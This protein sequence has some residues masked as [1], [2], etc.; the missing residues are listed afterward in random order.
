MSTPP[1]LVTIGLPV[2]NGERYLDG[3]LTSVLSQTYKDLELIISDN[4]STDATLDICRRFCRMDSRVRYMRSPSN[5]GAAWNYN[6]VFAHARGRYFRWLG[7]DDRCSDTYLAKL[8]EVLESEARTTVAVYP[9]TQW[10]DAEGRETT[11]ADPRYDL[12]SPVVTRRL[13]E[14]LRHVVYCNPV[15]GLIRAD[16]LRKTGL[17]RPFISSDKVLL[18]E[19]LLQ[20]KLLEYGEPLFYRRKHALSSC[21]ANRSYRAKAVWFDPRN[22]QRV[23][24]L[25]PVNVLLC[26]YIGAVMKS[27]LGPLQKTT[28]LL[29]VLR[30]HLR[31][32]TV[33]N[34]GGEWKLALRSRL[35]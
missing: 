6:H 29:V 4:G 3:A 5:R 22:A 32:Q 25:M 24:S 13:R 12:S 16:A 28:C 31:I 35:R 34:M 23:R 10:C 17:I 27:G 8:V 26:A 18:C 30:E 21:E 9:L 14:F 15:F 19:L 1:P 11:V 7:H 20:G 2:F 33:R